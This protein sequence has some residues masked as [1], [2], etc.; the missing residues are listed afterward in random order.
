[1]EPSGEAVYKEELT[2]D[3]FIK[4]R[5]TSEHQSILLQWSVGIGFAIN[6]FLHGHGIDSAMPR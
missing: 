4:F 5:N 3:G 6:H 1:M 2:E